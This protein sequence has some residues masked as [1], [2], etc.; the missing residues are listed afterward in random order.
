MFASSASAP[1]AHP[2]HLGPHAHEPGSGPASAGA[3][4]VSV[5]GAHAFP[6]EAAHL[7]ARAEGGMAFSTF[8]Q[9]FRNP[10][11]EPLE[12]VYVLPLPADGAVLGYRV[13]VGDRVIRGEIRTRE[14][15]RQAYRDALYQGRTAGLLEQERA[16]TFRQ[17]LGNI[18]ARTAVEVEIDVLHPLAF[19]PAT[20]SAD[21]GPAQWEYR[22]PTTV[23]VRYMGAAGRVP[24][25]GRI[26]PDRADPSEG[27]TPPRLTLALE[28]A[29]LL[30]GAGVVAPGHAL[31]LS[32]D[33][34]AMAEAE[35]SPS[36]SPGRH[37][38]ATLAEATRLDRDMV[39]RWD[40][41]A[42][43]IGVHLVEGTG[44]G[45]N[46]GGDR[47][48]E[49]ADAADRGR[50]A[51]VTVVPPA[52][53]GAA[54][55]RDLTIL[56]DTSGSMH[57]LPLEL[58]KAVVERLLRSLGPDDR[59]EV[60]TFGSRVKR[61]AKAPTVASEGAVDDAVKRLRRLEASGSTEMQAAVAEALR[62]LRS[63]AQRQVVLVTDGYIGF[64]GAV[65]A[66]A[67]HGLPAGVRFHAVG[68]GAAPN[69]TLTGGLARAGRG[70]ELFAQDGASAVESAELLLAA[71]VRPVLTDLALSGTAL[72]A[73]SPARPRDVA[74]G[75][76][77][78]LTV[79][80]AP[81]G[82][83]LE[84]SGHV[85]GPLAG[86][87]EPWRW[88]ARIP[89]RG[90]RVG[91]GSTGALPRTSLPLGALHGRERIADLEL[92][93]AAGAGRIE[94]DARIEAT[95][96]RHRIVSRRTSLVAVSDGPTVDPSEPTRRETVAVE[97]PGGMSAEMVGL[98]H[99]GTPR[100]SSDASTRVL[101][102]PRM[103]PDAESTTIREEGLRR[104]SDMEGDLDG[105]GPWDGTM[106]EIF[107]PGERFGETPDRSAPFR[108]GG[109]ESRERGR[110]FDLG[111]ARIL[112]LQRGELVLEIEVPHDGF[113]LPGGG[114]GVRVELGGGGVIRARVVEE[115]ST[116]VG[117]HQAGTRVRLALRLVDHGPWPTDET[118]RLAWDAHRPA[119][120]ASASRQDS[121]LITVHPAE[122]LA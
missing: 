114:T 99:Q 75:H 98:H 110:R 113:M 89:A 79:E 7:A 33:A 71:S 34:E 67:M 46:A 15:A 88:S 120:G 111:T 70:L 92:E 82:G 29:G 72:V 47:R 48:L 19:R 56:L 4:L 122:D 27:G 9:R 22:F 101:L 74:Q 91:D 12:V 26:D 95:A 30:P 11:A 57:G 119:T 39:A 80:L 84:L 18:P 17:Q 109:G 44:L 87:A 54:F 115:A 41:P 103:H 62:P 96:L 10:H 25:A 55:A 60:L 76:P 53:P 104:F 52:V 36:R 73:H 118:M 85:A 94:T 24:D 2:G 58:G 42:A 38:T 108:R 28:I 112:R 50:Y 31:E 63:D 35:G 83:T 37:V 5:D 117:P 51:L 59:F 68:V 69:R 23:G 81:G 20:P 64:E 100:L 78:V 13:T 6:L 105:D 116:R 65:V 49:D 90:P 106:D 32:E 8:R 40:A 121:F 45:G 86:N 43:E 93:E 107:A 14:V 3:A 66:E 102:A 77:V 16:D 97:L 21:A 61:F 1:H